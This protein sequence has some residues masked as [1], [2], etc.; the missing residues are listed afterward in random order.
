MINTG[1]QTHFTL[2]NNTS[3]LPFPTSLNSLRKPTNFGVQTNLPFTTRINPLAGITTAQSKALPIPGGLQN[4]LHD[5]QQSHV[6][7]HQECQTLGVRQRKNR[8]SQ[9]LPFYS[10]Y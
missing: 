4:E 8:R 9:S 6:P 7:G 10:W 1:R 2:G 3:T 5:G